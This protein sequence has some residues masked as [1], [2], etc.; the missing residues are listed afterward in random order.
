MN[1]ANR[2]I[3][4]RIADLGFTAQLPADWIAHDLPE[5]TPDFSEPAQCFPLA[6]ITA[7]YAA[8]V[9]AAAAR[10]AYEDGSL[11]DWATFLLN[12]N[13]L[14]PRAIG[15]VDIA[16]VPALAGEAV[17]ESSMGAMVVRFAFLEDGGRLINLSLSAPEPLADSVR[18]AWFALLS[19][20]TLESPRGSRFSADSAVEPAPAPAAEKVE[21]SPPPASDA[22]CTFAQFALADTAATLDQE[23]PVNASMRDRGAGFVPKIMVTDD[24]AK[25]ATVAAGAINAFCD[26]PYGWH[27]IDDGQRTVV[28]DP[29][30]A[31]Q[32]N[33]S[34][35]RQD[36]KSPAE[37]LDEIE[38]QMRSDY[39]DP[40]FCRLAQGK[41]EALGARNIA[42]GAQP[43]EQYHMLFPSHTVG[44]I[45]RAR[46]MTVPERRVD[47]CNLAGLILESYTGEPPSKPANAAPAPG[48]GPAWYQKAVALELENRLEEAEKA[49][50]SGCQ[51]IGFAQ[52]TAEL[53]F[54]RMLRLQKSGDE[55][56]A[57][58]AFKKS[59]SFIRFYASLATSGGE[60]MA[61][62]AERD[63]FRRRLVAAYGSDP[64][65]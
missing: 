49:I 30:G 33:L 51:D 32:I 36:R 44:M 34:L 23:H 35:L 29:K 57:L 24:D 45:L 8:I 55:T 52:A 43:L 46:V 13:E 18:E 11:H 39:P 2:T 53:Y 48:D 19:S 54:Q 25:R 64:E 27:I 6:L 59:S 65:A 14:A 7:P 17:Q 38:A 5:E 4:S 40:E 20:F 15:P 22:P 16:G 58:E 26:V 42:D 12:H 37:L 9:I 1:L 61:L 21:P 56:G 31:I 3:P 62:S 47:A 28:L 63:E 50:H 41:I 10:P 60:G